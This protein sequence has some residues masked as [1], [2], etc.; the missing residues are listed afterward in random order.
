MDVCKK[1]LPTYGECTKYGHNFIHALKKYDFQCTTFIKLLSVQ[2]RYVE[3]SFTKCHPNQPRKLQEHKEI[4]WCLQVKYNCHW[5]SIHKTH[6]CSTTFHKKG[7]QWISWKSNILFRHWYLVT[8]R[9]VD[10]KC[11]C[12]LHTRHCFLLHKESMKSNNL[13]AICISREEA[14]TGCGS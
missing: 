11:R 14:C 3:I 13:T 4:P 6:S 7:L 8:D 9:Q 10:E 2:K 1:S 12:G 5:T